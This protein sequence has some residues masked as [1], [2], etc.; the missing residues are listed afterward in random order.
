MVN[1]A[2][3]TRNED[4]RLKVGVQN[5]DDPAKKTQRFRARLCARGF[6]QQ[7]GIDYT[8]TFAPVVRYDSI[9]VLLAIAPEKDLELL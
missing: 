1:R 6:M 7:Q 4:D 9:R 2:Q 5:K 8:E 3:N